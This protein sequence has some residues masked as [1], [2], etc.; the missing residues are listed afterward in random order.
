MAVVEVESGLQIAF[1]EHGTGV[2]LSEK[3]AVETA[4]AICEAVMSRYD[5]FSTEEVFISGEVG[6]E[7]TV[8]IKR[9]LDRGMI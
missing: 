8:R 4:A 3:D 2:Q 6:G 7:I 1:P 9:N 5:S